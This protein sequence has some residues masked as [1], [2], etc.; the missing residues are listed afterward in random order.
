M[1]GGELKAKLKQ[2]KCRKV[3]ERTKHEMW[4][5]PITEKYFY[6]PRHDSQ[7][8]DAGTLHKILKQAGLK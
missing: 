1:N 5:S 7:E 4:Y 3:A 8:V 6:V 2:S